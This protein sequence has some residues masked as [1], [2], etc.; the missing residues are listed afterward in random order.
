MACGAVSVEDLLTPRHVHSQRGGNND[1]GGHGSADGA[2]N[3]GLDT[4]IESACVGFVRR[5]SVRV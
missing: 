1:P 4:L 5:V 3:N 2:D